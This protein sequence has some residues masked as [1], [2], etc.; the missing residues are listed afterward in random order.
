MRHHEPQ[1]RPHD[2]CDKVLL[3]TVGEEDIA[4]YLAQAP[5]SLREFLAAQNG[6][7]NTKVRPS[8]S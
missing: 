2:E 8:A 1:A 7:K 4:K 3:R 5:V 6:R